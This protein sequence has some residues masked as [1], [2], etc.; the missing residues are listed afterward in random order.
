MTW[1]GC[2]WVLTSQNR[3][4][5]CSPYLRAS[6]VGVLFVLF[7]L[8]AFA[9]GTLMQLPPLTTSLGTPIAGATINVFTT[10]GNLPNL[11]CAS[12]VTVYKDAGLTLPFTTLTTDGGG[13]YPFFIQPLSN[14]Y[15]FTVSGVGT[16][17]SQCYGFSAPVP[18]LSSPAFTNLTAQ[19]YNNIQTINSLTA[20]ADI[21]AKIATGIALL[22]VGGGTVDAR[23]FQGTQAC[24]S[25]PVAVLPP[26]GSAITLLLG[27]VNIQSSSQWL[28]S[29]DVGFRM[30]GSGPRSTTLQYTGGAVDAFIKYSQPVPA[31]GIQQIYLANMLVRGSANVTDVILAKG[32]HR[33]QFE[34]LDIKDATQS[35]FHTMWAVTDT[36]KNLSCSTSSGAFVAIPTYGFMFDELPTGLQTTD[37]T[38]TDFRAEGIKTGLYLKSASSMTFTSGTSENNTAAVGGAQIDAPSANNIF[39]GTD[40]EANSGGTDVLDNGNSNIC[41]DCIAISTTG[42]NMGATSVRS[43]VTGGN[44]PTIVKNAAATSPGGV[45]TAAQWVGTSSGGTNIAG[46]EAIAAAPGY[47]WENTGG[48]ADAKW[49]DQTVGGNTMI[50]RLLTDNLGTA[51][52]W[53]AV[54]RSGIASATIDMSASSSITLPTTLALAYKTTTNCAAVGTAASPSVAACGSAAAGQFSCATNATGATCQVNT[55]AVTANSEIFVFESDTAVTGTRLGVTCN[56][57]TTVNPATRLLASSVAGAS[58]TINLGTVTTNPA[59]FSYH[60]VN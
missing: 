36:Y 58:F 39:L 27:N 17:T 6:V 26:F 44:V 35:C 2:V 32:T 21:C 28:I 51:L 52:T 8:P 11:V 22:P 23:F 38:V 1:L 48:G 55:T 4:F 56:T 53:M 14:P 34:L 50:F 13:N 20:G 40:F 47:S 19:S 18:P 49:W 10:T 43:Q 3:R 9:Q 57:G 46:F 24:A 31:N 59:C 45:N 5:R 30:I 16:A 41:I 37:G 25:N 33:S 54:T 60:I 42:W 15:G 7:T 29:Q 12:P